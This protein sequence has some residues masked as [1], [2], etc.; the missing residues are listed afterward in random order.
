[1]MAMTPANTNVFYS[2]QTM[3]TAPANANVPVFQPTVAT[4]PANVKAPVLHPSPKM[5]AM[6]PASSPTNPNNTN[7]LTTPVLYQYPTP[8]KP[9]LSTLEE[10]NLKDV[11]GIRG[12]LLLSF[13]RFQKQR[14]ES[15]EGIKNIKRRNRKGRK[16]GARK[17]SEDN[18]RNS[19]DRFLT[20]L[21]DMADV[22]GEVDIQGDSE[23]SNHSNSNRRSR[24]SMSP[25]SMARGLSSR[26]RSSSGASFKSALDTWAST[27]P[28]DLPNVFC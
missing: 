16:K 5:A 20:E 7:K 1:M 4:A 18:R 17:F 25:E 28:A 22:L 26:R 12:A 19:E 21:N 27:R 10:E 14:E 24:R 11:N 3:A 2:N 23:H 9:L 6:A 13:M 8:V 15:A